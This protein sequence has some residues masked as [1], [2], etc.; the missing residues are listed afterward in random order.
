ML[1]AADSAPINCDEIFQTGDI[2][3]VDETS[4]DAFNQFDLVAVGT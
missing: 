2:Y 1:D 3:G 4:I